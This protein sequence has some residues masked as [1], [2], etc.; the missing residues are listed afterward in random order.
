MFHR[1]LRTFTRAL[2]AFALVPVAAL[3]QGKTELLVYTALEADQIKAY[4]EAFEKEHPNISLK[5]VRDSTGIITAKLLAEK[6]N[7]QADVIWG[8]AAT[9]LMLLDR[10]GMLMPY[11]PKNLAAIKPNMRDPRNPPT[12]VGMDVWSSAICFN[13][14]EA[15]KRNLP[16]PTSWEDLTRPVYRGAITMPHPAS[17]GTG[18]LMV[19]AWLQMMGEQKGW[20]FMDALHQNIGVYTHSGS[21]PCRQAGAG[22]Y[23]IGLSFEYRA[24]KT[25]KDGAPIDIILPREGLG[26]DMEAT[27]ILKTTKKPEAAKALADFAASRK[28]NELY[29]KNFAIVAIP[30]IQ[31]KLEFIDADIEK[32]LVKNDF[33]WAAANRE[34]ILTEWSRRYEAKAEK[35]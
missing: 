14:V 17:S 3:A 20:A 27:A 35:R 25:K 7:P 26:W 18:Y 13:T 8:L 22:E 24:N 30:G 5:F 33:A 11:A 2:S 12:W 29:A 28:A 16:K 10:E 19:S 9:S 32:Q 4:Q 34:R 31:E 6:A 23:P 15:A 21:K 1:I